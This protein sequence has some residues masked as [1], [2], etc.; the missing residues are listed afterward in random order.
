MGFAAESEALEKHAGEKLKAKGLQLV[1]ANDITSKDSGF[2]SDDNRVVVIGSDG[3]AE[4]L[5]LM[6]KYDVAWVVLDRV[7]S[8]LG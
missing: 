5:E 6:S 7:L 4:R 3:E 2:G 1:V 8:L